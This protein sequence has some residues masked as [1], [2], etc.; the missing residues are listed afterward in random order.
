[1][2]SLSL[3]QQVQQLRDQIEA[4]NYAYY[5]LDNPVVSDAQYDDLYRQL[6][7]LEQTH[8]ELITQDSPTQRVGDQ[9]L[10]GFSPVVHNVPMLS[11][12][13]AFSDDELAAFNQ[14][15]LERLAGVAE[16]TYAAEPKMDGLAV[17][18]RYEN[19]HL[20]QAATRGD[21]AVGEDVTHNVRTIRCIPLKLRGADLPAVLEV[22]GEVFMSKA[23]LAKINQAQLAKGDKAFAN[24]R[25]AAAGSLRQ[26]DPKITAQ[27]PL[28][29][30]CYGWGAISDD[31]RL[32]SRYSEMIEQLHQWGLPTNP[33]AQVVIGQPGLVAY[34][35]KL[36]ALRDQLD[37]EIDGIVY[38]VD[39]LQSQRQLGFTSKFPRW[40]IARKFPA[41]E[42]W[43]KLLG[44]DIQV[45]RTGALT[46]VA[47]LEPVAVG[48]VMVSNATLHNLDEIQRK[49][50]RV[51][52]TVIVRRA[53]DVIPEVVGAVLSQ[54]PPNAELFSMP[55]HCPECG[56]DVV[57]ELDK[58]VYV[59]TGGLFCPAQRKRALEHF[60]SRKAMDIQG[61]GDKLIA[62]Q[63]D[64]GLVQHPDDFYKLKLSQLTALERMAEKSAQNVLDAIE[65]SKNTTLARFIYA[66]G[67]PEVGEVTAKQL[68]KH[69][70][71]LDAVMRA[72]VAALT[73]V[74]DV[75]EVVANHVL[76]FFQQPHNREVIDGLLD[77]GIR[78]PVIEAPLIA[79]DS[80]F[81]GKTCVLTGT[82]EK[83]TR[84]DAKAQLEALGAK[85]SGS[86]SAK[87]DYVIAGDKAGSK[88]S[89]AEQLGVRVL[90]EDAFIALLGES[91]G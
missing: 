69:F 4:H 59:C 28:S 25:N 70:L 68:A 86:V 78:W 17:N 8:P 88:L 52:D 91:N 7:A 66:L 40:A 49:D 44:I 30:F 27:R 51:G 32:L 62:Q 82:L 26:L 35:N 57:K 85:V 23:A 1:M 76:H 14:R 67:I 45:G 3:Q 22:R 15:A 83:M 46:P 56:S 87:T 39:N 42:V 61:L 75:G 5:V 65:A 19:G 36:L 73:E 60:V 77:A 64:A 37:Y 89:K 41:Q 29:F 6:V 43:T 34:Y 21:G 38:K 53:G 79:H 80:V 12:D 48:G 71:T 72:D 10:A 81:A 63:V 20:V 50:V 31:F 24:P 58:A 9:P 90:T 55:H 18:L 13:N 2:T 84:E 16:I 74:P 47:R 11:L 54:R 33:L